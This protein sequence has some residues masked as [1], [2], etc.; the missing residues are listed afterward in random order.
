VGDRYVWGA[1]GPSSWDCSGLTMKA[2]R[3]AGISI[4]HSSSSQ[5]YSYRHISK[6]QLQPGDLVFFYSPIHHVGIYIGGGM[7]VHAANPRSGVKVASLNS[8]PYSGASRP[9]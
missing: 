7:I 1:T 9:Y 5:Y 6:S 2:Y 3:V 4:P 8:M